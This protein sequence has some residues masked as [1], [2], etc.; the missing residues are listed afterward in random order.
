VA[1]CILSDSA[2]LVSDNGL[3]ALNR[4][5]TAGGWLEEVQQ[6]SG[7][8]LLSI[9]AADRG[10]FAAYSL[11]LGEAVENGYE[12]ESSIQV[13][14]LDESAPVPIR[15]DSFVLN[16]SDPS[17]CIEQTLFSYRLAAGGERVFL[18]DRRTP[19]YL[20]DC[21]DLEGRLL[22]SIERDVP[23]V[24]KSPSEL[25]REAQ[26]MT[27]LLNGMGGSELIEHTYQPRSW[28]EPVADIWVTEDGGSLWVLR[29]D[30]EGYL[31]D[32]FDAASGELISTAE[33]TMDTTGVEDVRFFVCEDDLICLVL[34]DDSFEQTIVVLRPEPESSER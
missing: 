17:E 13:W 19:E 28:R 25:Q 32:V 9:R 18:F 3:R 6:F 15:V 24:D 31:F 7:D 12:T 22:Y 21:F 16:P 10:S 29:G 30:L 14:T 2:L 1:F 26:E 33:V 4:F 20:V 8:P 23:V 5:T 34:E 27:D 11:S